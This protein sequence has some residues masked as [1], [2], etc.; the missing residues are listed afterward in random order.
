MP[1]FNVQ[2]TVA[3]SLSAALWAVINWL[4]APIFWQLT[5]LPIL[6]DMIG[7]SLLILSAWWTKKPG[8]ASFMGLVAT[9]LNFILRPGATHF[10]GFTVASIFFDFSTVLVG[11]GNSLEKGLRNTVSLSLISII[12]TTI[13][14]FIIGT[15]FMNPMFLTNMFGGVVLFAA[16]HGVGGLIGS[17]LGIIIIRGLEVRQ[18]IPR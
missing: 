11:Y 15:F 3:V 13:A 6:C 17:V 10:I 1:Y 2:E 14:G 7:V 5:H 8:A 4:V 16:L 12:S 9:I 18:V